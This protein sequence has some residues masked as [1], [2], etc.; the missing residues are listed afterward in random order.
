VTCFSV[1]LGVLRFLALRWP[2]ST[3][4]RGTLETWLVPLGG[5]SV[6]ALASAL[7]QFAVHLLGYE[8]WLAKGVVLMAVGGGIAIAALLVLGSIIT[9]TGDDTD[10]DTDTDTDS[11]KDVVEGNQ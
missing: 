8:S 1:C 5:V 4:S 3:D 10:S 2:L 6:L 9:I 11:E 7:W